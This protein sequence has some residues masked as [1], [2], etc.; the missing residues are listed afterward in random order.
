MTSCWN[1]SSLVFFLHF[2]KPQCSLSETWFDIIF[3]KTA[4][5]S[6]TTGPP[7]RQGASLCRGRLTTRRRHLQE[8]SWHRFHTL[9]N[10][11]E[12]HF[13]P[14]FCIIQLHFFF[15]DISRILPIARWANGEGELKWTRDGGKCKYWFRQMKPAKCD[16]SMGA[17]VERKLQ[18]P[19]LPPFPVQVLSQSVGLSARKP[20]LLRSMVNQRTAQGLC[21]GLVLTECR[22]SA[23]AVAHS[24]TQSYLHPSLCL[25]KLRL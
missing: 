14:S 2:P 22:P 24:H 3:P 5:C 13:L 8:R 10:P 16:T 9:Q 21:S 19:P 23:L 25:F 6:C 20:E 11:W 4:L 7:G 18:I 15:F 1:H 17:S 12:R